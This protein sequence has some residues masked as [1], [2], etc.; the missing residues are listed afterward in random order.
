[1][2][3]SGVLFLLL[4]IFRT[5]DWIVNAVPNSLKLAVSAGIGYFYSG[6]EVLNE[7]AFM[8]GGETRASRRIKLITE[9]YVLPEEVG[10]ILSGGIRVIGDR[11]NT[12]IG[13]LAG[14]SGDEAGCC[15]PLI[16]FSYSFGR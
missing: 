3:V 16:N 15:V 6:D 8:V 11:F 1:M 2:F 10:V 14:V 9:N 4:S 13:I 5:R 7:P 12:E